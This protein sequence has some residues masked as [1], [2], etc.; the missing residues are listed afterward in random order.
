MIL[1]GVVANGIGF[2][3]SGQLALVISQVEGTGIVVGYSV[4]ATAL[5]AVIVERTLGLFSREALPE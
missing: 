2:I 1:E 4:V 3:Y 5:I